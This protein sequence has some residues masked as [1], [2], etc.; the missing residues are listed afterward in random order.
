VKSKGKNMTYKKAYVFLVTVGL[1]AMAA[2][3]AQA[4]QKGEGCDL[5]PTSDGFVALR[6]GPSTKAQRIHKLKPDIHRI[7]P[8]RRNNSWVHVSIGGYGDPEEEGVPLKERNVGDGYV[9]S[10]LIDW[11]SC[12]MAG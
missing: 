12:S 7:F 1:G 10:N 11:S 9:K 4:F 2:L 8:D 6:T 3:Q 5:K